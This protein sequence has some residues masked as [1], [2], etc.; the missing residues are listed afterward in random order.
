VGLAFLLSPA[1]AGGGPAVT[2][3]LLDTDGVPGGEAGVT[4]ALSGDD[5]SAVSAG[6]DIVYPDGDL[7]FTEPVSMSCVLDAR[8]AST[9]QVAGRILSPGTVNV[10][11]SVLGAPNPLPP[12]GNGDLAVCSFGISADAMDG[13]MFPVEA[14]NVFV[15]DDLGAE[16]GSSAQDGIVS[17]GGGPTPTSTPTSTPTVTPPLDCTNDSDCPTGLTCQNDVCLPKMCTNDDDCPPGSSCDLGGDAA[18]SGTGP[19]TCV[20]RPC[21]DDAECN[22]PSSV[23]DDDGMCRPQFCT[24]DADC[25]AGEQCTDG[26]CEVILPECE[27]DDQ[28]PDGVCEGKTCVD[29]REDSDCTM[30]R[31][32]SND[33]KCVDTG[34][35]GIG[36]GRASGLPGSTVSVE[37]TLSNASGQSAD[38]ARNY[39]VAGSGLTIADCTASDGI[40]GTFEGIPGT[41][42]AAE[43]GGG[44]DGVPVG[45]IYECSVSISE[46]LAAG[47]V[48]IACP[49]AEVNG[50]SVECSDGGVD[51]IAEPTPTPVDTPT[52]MPTATLTPPDTPTATP[53]PIGGDDG[54]VVGPVSSNSSPA[55]TMLL[56]LLPAMLLW[57]RRRR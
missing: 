19:G 23:C 5:G 30:G 51:V 12:L 14:D 54:C 41:T 55:G 8:I 44:S 4:L 27:N 52:V 35:F 33:N 18:T 26:V 43:V 25:D 24:D 17:V 57:R 9:H 22:D 29:C 11:I 37:V 38:M 46:G 13:D 3:S 56:L 32:C 39:L 6:V 42:V 1:F 20:P 50:A 34:V 48:A 10:E 47:T 21:M 2:F 53:R 31:V 28:C 7:S 40:T 36:V 15:G 16:I 49:M 45:V